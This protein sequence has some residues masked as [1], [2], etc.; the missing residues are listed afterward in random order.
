MAKFDFRNS[1]Y[2]KFFSD[3]ENQNFLQTFINREDILYTNYGWYLTQGRKASAATPTNASGI[4][5]F[6]VKGR[7]LNA[8]PYMDL[9]APLG[10][11]NQMD[12]GQVIFCTG[13]IPDFIANGRKETAMERKY[14]EDMF[15]QFGSDADIVAEFVQDV[16]QMVDSADSTMNLL[17]ARLMST[18]KID[19]SDI[20]RGIRVPIS[21]APIPEENFV[22]A[23]ETVWS[24]T[25]NCKLL[26]QMKK[27]EDEY[28]DKRD[29]RGQLVWQVPY[30][31]FHEVILEN[32]QVKELISNYAHN[33][34]MWR[35]T[36]EG[37]SYTE[38]LF[39]QAVADYQGISPIEIVVEKGRNITHTTDTFIHGW[40]ENVAVLRP[41][42]DAVEFEYTECLDRLMTE[43]YGSNLMT[44]V[45]AT[46]NNGLGTLVNITK[47]NGRFQ[48][49]QTDL[50]MSAVPAL[51]EFP[52]HLIVDTATADETSTSTSTSTEETTEETTE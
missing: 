18:G 15:T 48:E 23:G 34:L 22:T 11:S 8:A 20:G 17:T 42:G 16:Q 35:A 43:R 19:Y 33:P 25:E 29:F 26:E 40:S 21:S 27:I 4:A 13:T 28:R 5:S 3:K 51:I 10:D 24:D 30:Q 32:A 38:Q 47:N 31:M 2:A 9:R 12:Q 49:W 44:S 6:T 36:V 39:R 1:R 7:K 45:F 50:Y 37:Q 14:R 46:T 52:D 41:A